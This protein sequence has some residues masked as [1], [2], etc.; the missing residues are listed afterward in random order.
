METT[1]TSF[2]DTN[3][4]ELLESIELGSRTGRGMLQRGQPPKW[5]RCIGN[6]YVLWNATW[7]GQVFTIREHRLVMEQHLGRPLMEKET[8]HHKNGIRDDNRVENLE[9]WYGRHPQGITHC[10]HCGE[11]I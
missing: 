8:V 1:D 3:V 5:S 9:L 7:Q 2:I 4:D 11:R 10:P 6:G